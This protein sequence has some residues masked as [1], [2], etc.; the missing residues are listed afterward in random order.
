VAYL[1]TQALVGLQGWLD[2]RPSVPCSAVFLNR[3]NGQFSVTGIQL[4]LAAY[5]RKAGIWLTCH[6]LRH[7][8]ARH[9]VEAGVPVTSVQRLLGH[10][11]MRTTETYL[12]I[13]DSQVQADY[14]AA[15]AALS[16]RLALGIGGG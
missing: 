6:Q 10:A 13:S 9:L 1:S 2:E 4:C 7:T 8:F 14:Q 12:S 3:F 16:G 15:M 11:R 5:C